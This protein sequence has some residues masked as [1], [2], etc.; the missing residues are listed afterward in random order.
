MDGLIVG[1]ISLERK[2]RP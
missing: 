2:S 1:R